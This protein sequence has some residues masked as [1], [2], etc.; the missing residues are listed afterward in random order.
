MVSAIAVQTEGWEDV[1]DDA[2]FSSGALV[3]VVIIT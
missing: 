3:Q 2:R 1:A